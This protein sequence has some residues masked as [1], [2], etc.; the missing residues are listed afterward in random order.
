[1]FTRQGE[2]PDVSFPR[3]IGIEFIGTVA[4]YPS[5]AP[6]PGDP[7]IGT[8]VAT[9]MGG[10]GRQIPGSYAEYAC[11]WTKY[12]RALPETN[13]PV[14][15]LAAL[16]EM[17]QTV[18]GSLVHG[19]DLRK[20][21]S[22]L[23]RGATSSIGLAALQ[24]SRYLGASRLGATSRSTAREAM[25]KQH[26]ADEV[27][28]DDGKVSARVASQYD[29]VLELV[30]TTTLKDSIKC[31]RPG[32]MVCMTGIQGGEW[33]M[34]D[35]SPIT[36]LP[37]RRRL[38]GYGGGADDFAT[39]PLEELVKAVEQDRIKVPVKTF[40]LDEIQRVHELMEAGGGG[41]KMVVEL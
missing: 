3:I 26:G 11:P 31:L 19:L 38:T 41:A 22:V 5:G 23:V 9:C 16:P 40:S 18:Y 10:L 35:F 25:L 27:F 14:S 24:V 6:S 15:T 37:D 32:G 8:R 33:M 39:L 28:V 1:M 21:E 34:K 2:S 20:G 4:G 13:L 12:V 30:G 7:P 29:K 17:M 36:D